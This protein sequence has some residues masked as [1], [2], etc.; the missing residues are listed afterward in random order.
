[1]RLRCE[2]ISGEFPILSLFRNGASQG[3]SEEQGR[4]LRRRGSE[5]DGGP[6]HMQ[7]EGAGKGV[8]ITPGRGRRIV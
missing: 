3:L 4:E 7:R 8:S 5:R 1:M 2:L 6:S